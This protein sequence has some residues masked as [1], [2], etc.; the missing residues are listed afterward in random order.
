MKTPTDRTRGKTDTKIILK[1]VKS[2][3]AWRGGLHNQTERI[4]FLLNIIKCLTEA[5]LY[6]VN[7]S[8]YQPRSGE[9]NG[10]KSE[11]TSQK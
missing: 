2:V 6:I 5:G 4:V 9:H 7:F 8:N 1:L 10:E 11:I 3:C